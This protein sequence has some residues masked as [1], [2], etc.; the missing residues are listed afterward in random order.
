MNVTITPG[1]LQGTITP[2]PSKSQAHRVL[3]AAALSGGGS[4]LKNVAL[5]QDIEATIR[6][7]EALG[8]SFRWEGATLAVAGLA[9]RPSAGGRLP[10]LDCGEIGRASC[11]ERV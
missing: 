7:L 11:R 2:P 9:G 3:I 10:E 5:S 1:P 4:T 8:A 6:C